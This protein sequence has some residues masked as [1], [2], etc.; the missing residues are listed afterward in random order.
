M[1]NLVKEMNI[2][3]AICESRENDKIVRLMNGD[4]LSIE[5]ILAYQNGNVWGVYYDEDSDLVYEDL[6]G[7]VHIICK[8]FELS[9]DEQV[10]FCTDDPDYARDYI[11]YAYVIQEDG[12]LKHIEFEENTS[13]CNDVAYYQA[14]DGGFALVAENDQYERSG[15]YYTDSYEEFVE[16]YGDEDVFNLK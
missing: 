7:E 2:S 5:F 9:E 16:D 3:Q 13:E 15:I 12:T 11:Q 14:K 4:D 10:M 1:R 8:D 6:Q